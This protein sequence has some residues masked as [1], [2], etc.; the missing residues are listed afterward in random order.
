MKC[1]VPSR[2]EAASTITLAAFLN[3]YVWRHGRFYARNVLAEFWP[4]SSQSAVEY[5]PDFEVASP[6][7]DCYLK[8]DFESFIYVVCRPRWLPMESPSNLRWWMTEFFGAPRPD[9]SGGSKDQKSMDALIREY[10]SARPQQLKEL[11]CYRLTG[12]CH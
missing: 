3:N 7:C 10:T 6:V 2:K 4:F 11:A 12:G 9:G 5:A 1:P 8:E